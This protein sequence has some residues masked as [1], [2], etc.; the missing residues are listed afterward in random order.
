MLLLTAIV[1]ALA[2]LILAAVLVTVV[3][4]AVQRQAQLE[5]EIAMWKAAAEAKGGFTYERLA[6]AMARQDVRL[7][8]LRASRLK[9][10]LDE[11]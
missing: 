11:H 5:H 8:E 9:Q 4:G 7:A 3:K 1:F 10:G 2:S 6:E